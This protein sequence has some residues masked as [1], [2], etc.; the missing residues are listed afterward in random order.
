MYDNLEDYIQLFTPS[1]ILSHR[2]ERLSL[3]SRYLEN[4]IR[5]NGQ[6]Q[7]S[8]ICTHNS[9]RSQLAQVWGQIAAGYF[10]QPVLCFSGGTEA[11][12]FHAAAIESLQ[13]AGFE[14]EKNNGPN[15]KFK[16]SYGTE[17]PEIECFSK[18]F[19]HEINPAQDFAAVMTC[20]EADENCPVVP[21]ADQRFSL[22]YTDPKYAD[23]SEIESTVYDAT[24]Y[25]IGNEMFYLFSQIGQS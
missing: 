12:S 15:A 7:L 9:R 24:S 3:I 19:S 10:K 2:K 13:R 20:T 4:K 1:I 21:G 17:E 22:P 18:I 23:N 14:I 5:H 8:F 11:T 16:I 25:K 6:A